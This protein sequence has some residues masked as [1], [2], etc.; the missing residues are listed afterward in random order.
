MLKRLAHLGDPTTTGGKITIT[1]GTATDFADGRIIAR[2]GDTATCPLCG[3]S[4][5]IQCIASPLMSFDGIPVAREGDYVL[6]DCP[7][8]TNLLKSSDPASDVDDEEGMWF[9][10]ALAGIL[11]LIFGAIGTALD[12]LGGEALGAVGA[13]LGDDLGEDLDNAIEGGEE[14]GEAAGE[15]AGAA[16]GED[17]GNAAE[18]EGGATAGEDAGEKAGANA[19]KNAKTG[20]KGADEEAATNKAGKNTKENNGKNKSGNKSDKTGEKNSGKQASTPKK[21]KGGG[22]SEAEAE[23]DA[24]KIKNQYQKQWK[25]HHSDIKKIAKT[26]GDKFTDQD[27]KDLVATQQVSADRIP[28]GNGRTTVYLQTGNSKAGLEHILKEHSKD[29]ENAGI[30]K[31]QIANVI[32]KALKKGKIIGHQGKKTPPR[33]VYQVKYH[34]KEVQ[35][36]IDVSDNGYITGANPAHLK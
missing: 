1:A 7:P 9:Q 11:A 5:L 21:K 27:K 2:Q 6:C 23:A 19:G 14:A 36:A 30:P 20:E 15:E 33:T 29:F 12:P 26:N 31:K 4:G 24:T 25:V 18:E 35:I 32:M 34:G 3:K 28:D 13:A 8:G 16:A 17:A 10:L 22:E